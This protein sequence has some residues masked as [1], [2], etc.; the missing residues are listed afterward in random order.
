MQQPPLGLAF[1]VS[2]AVSHLA[3]ST[4]PGLLEGLRLGAHA[5]NRCAGPPE[6]AW[7]E[8]GRPLF[9]SEFAPPS[10]IGGPWP[11]QAVRLAGRSLELYPQV[12]DKTDNSTVELVASGFH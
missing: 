1:R 4:D 9:I 7:P 10:N 5:Y 8:G 12:G 3:P 2:A 6:L 11:A